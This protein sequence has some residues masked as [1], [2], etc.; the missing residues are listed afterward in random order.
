LTAGGRVSAAVLS[1]RFGTVPISNFSCSIISICGLILRDASKVQM[2]R[3]RTNEDSST[4]VAAALKNGS[5]PQR[6]LGHNP[7]AG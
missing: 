2:Q 4:L 7:T 3:V 5:R 1:N 6:P